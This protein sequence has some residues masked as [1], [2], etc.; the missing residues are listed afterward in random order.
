MRS[1]QAPIGTNNTNLGLYR[2]KIRINLLL[3]MGQGLFER[4]KLIVATQ[5]CVAVLKRGG[6]LQQTKFDYLVRGPRNSTTVNPL[7]DWL[8]EAVWSSVQ[9]LKVDTHWCKSSNI[10]RDANLTSTVYMVAVQTANITT[11]YIETCVITL[12]WLNYRCGKTVWF[13]MTA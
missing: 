3:C 10:H 8:P 11:Y 4:H 6:K 12:F 13:C 9:A 7:K 5:L 1:R 2:A